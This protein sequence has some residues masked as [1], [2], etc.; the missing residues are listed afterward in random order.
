MTTDVINSSKLIENFPIRAGGSSY[1]HAKPSVL[2][3]PM[4]CSQASDMVGS[5]GS[6]GSVNVILFISIPSVLTF[7][8]RDIQ[9]WMSFLSC[10]D[11]VCDPFAALEEVT[12][13]I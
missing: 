5:V 8:S 13:A 9:R 2:Y 1:R 3:P 11:G 7:C 10:F 6:V 12:Q 4:P